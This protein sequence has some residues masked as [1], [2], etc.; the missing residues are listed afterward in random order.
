MDL[1]K[2]KF[3]YEDNNILLR[4][5]FP[6]AMHEHCISWIP[7]TTILDQSI[8]TQTRILKRVTETSIDLVS[9]N[10]SNYRR[11]EEVSEKINKYPSIV[12]GIYE[13]LLAIHKSIHRMKKKL[14]IPIYRPSED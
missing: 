8:R 13:D 1:I 7:P 5:H 6:E 11:F 14:N 4:L 3:L 10:Q 2:V 12:K 9:H